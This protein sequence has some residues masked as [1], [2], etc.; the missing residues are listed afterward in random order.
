M[1]NTRRFINAVGP[2]SSISIQCS[3]ILLAFFR[4]DDFHTFKGTSS[5]KVQKGGSRNIKL[6]RIGIFQ[7]FPRQLRVDSDP[8]A[9]GRKKVKNL[10]SRSRLRIK[11]K[12]ERRRIRNNAQMK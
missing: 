5:I 4:D 7:T 12:A 8:A 3:F 9:R 1:K 2:I 11:S 10:P 6:S